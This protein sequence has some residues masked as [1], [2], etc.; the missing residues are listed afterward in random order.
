MHKYIGNIYAGRGGE[1]TGQIF[2]FEGSWMLRAPAKQPAQRLA[3]RF[4]PLALRLNPIVHFRR[5]QR[6]TREHVAPGAKVGRI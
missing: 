4:P 6:T 2:G 3:Q 5:H 1:V